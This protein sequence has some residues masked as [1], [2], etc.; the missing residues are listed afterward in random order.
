MNFSNVWDLHSITIGA[1][2]A[3]RNFFTL[4][5]LFVQ[6]SPNNLAV[7]GE[8]ETDFSLKNCTFKL[9]INFD[10]HNVGLKFS[11]F[12]RFDLPNFSLPSTFKDAVEEGGESLVVT[13]LSCDG[14]GQEDIAVKVGK[15]IRW[16]NGPPVYHGS[17]VYCY[18]G[19][20]QG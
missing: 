17:S 9:Q 4:L 6:T 11:Y 1:V 2:I 13:F 18:G 14:D 7:A 20:G 12:L 5:C 10:R 8:T 15:K 19:D 16:Y 3:V